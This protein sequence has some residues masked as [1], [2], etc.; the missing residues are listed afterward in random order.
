MET[1]HREQ[2]DLQHRAHVNWLTQGDQGS[3]FFAR[4][5]KARQA[6][7]SVMRTIDEEERQTNS[8]EEMKSMAVDYFTTLYVAENRTPPIPNLN[9]N[10]ENRPSVEEN[11]KLRAFPN[12]EEIWRTLKSMSNSKT[13]RMDGIT[14]EIIAYHWSHIKKDILQA[15][16][17][18]FRTKQM[19]IRSLNLAVL[20]LI[21]KKLTPKKLDDYRPISCL[22]VVYK[23]FSKILA[24]H[25]MSILPGIISPN[26][27]AFIK[28]KKITDVIGLAQEFT[29]SYNCKSTSR[30][31]CVAID[32]SKAFDTLPPLGCN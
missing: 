32:F 17:H 26:Q 28:G 21:P 24:T 25:L 10:A 2:L 15:V 8:M 3:K 4:A 5:I 27:T 6:R 11:A 12:E 20:T 29:L 31:A 1:T 23:I 18:F 14:L 16:F 30:R 22:G 19:L 7:N 13:P 9:L